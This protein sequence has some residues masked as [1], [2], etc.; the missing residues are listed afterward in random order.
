MQTQCDFP[1][2]PKVA[3]SVCRH[4]AGLRLH[5]D[6]TRDE[7]RRKFDGNE[8]YPN[9]SSVAYLLFEAAKMVSGW[10]GVR[11]LV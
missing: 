9:G 3:L 4:P 8:R 11:S 5:F 2:S 7:T 6:P 10:F 1:S